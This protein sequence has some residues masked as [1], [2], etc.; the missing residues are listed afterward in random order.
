MPS[1]GEHFE[2]LGNQPTEVSSPS[3]QHGDIGRH[4]MR[5]KKAWEYAQIVEAE[6]TW[7]AFCSEVE[8][9]PAITDSALKAYNHFRKQD[10]NSQQNPSQETLAAYNLFNAYKEKHGFY[11]VKTAFDAKN[12]LDATEDAT[13]VHRIQEQWDKFIN[14]LDQENIRLLID[15]LEYTATACKSRAC[16]SQADIDISKLGE[17][18]Q[19]TLGFVIYTGPNKFA[20]RYGQETDPIPKRAKALDNL[21]QLPKSAEALNNLLQSSDSRET[22]LQRELIGNI[23]ALQEAINSAAEK[24]KDQQAIARI[25]ER[26]QNRLLEYQLD[27]L[28]ATNLEHLKKNVPYSKKVYD[29]VISKIKGKDQKIQRDD[30]L[31]A[32]KEIKTYLQS[33]SQ[34]QYVDGLKK[35]L[36]DLEDKW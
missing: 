13:E 3:S 31:N 14:K 21:L 2:N 7:K 29:Y 36:A 34:G 33:A 20:D 24:P 17:S 12:I 19:K 28:T 4:E 23:N 11:R 5:M 1:P 9:A 15:N 27:N 10:Y 30:A 32:L 6:K 26:E 18:I 22:A 8:E 16:K 25:Q 35:E